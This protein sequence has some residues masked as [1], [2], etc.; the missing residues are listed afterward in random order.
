MII[1][2]IRVILVTVNVRLMEILSTQQQAYAKLVIFHAKIVMVVL[3]IIVL[4]AK[5]EIIWTMD[6]V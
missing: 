5:T 2:F 4:Y 6:H 3:T 1:S